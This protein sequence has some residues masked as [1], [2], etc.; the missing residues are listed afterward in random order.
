MGKTQGRKLLKKPHLLVCALLFFLVPA[1]LK[2]EKGKYAAAPSNYEMVE[3]PTAFTLLHGGYDVIVRMYEGGGLFLRGNIGFHDRFM[4]GFSGN[5]TNVVGHG[6]ID[7]QEPR[8][9]VKWKFLSQDRFPVALAAAWDDRGYG[10]SVGHR[11]TPGL[12][13]GLYVAV[14]RE[15]KKP[16]FLQLHGGANVVRFKDYEAD[17]DLGFFGGTSFAFSNAFHLSLEF[18]K[19]PTDFWQFNAGFVLAFDEPIQIGMD[20][21]DINRHESFARILRIQ[22]LSFF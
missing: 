18:D 8:L 11:F 22:Y 12:Q 21:R 2:A 5:A 1:V 20:F 13:K 14:S 7:V 3:A 10:E 6:H 17:N 4:F 15:L 19:V 9:A 16:A